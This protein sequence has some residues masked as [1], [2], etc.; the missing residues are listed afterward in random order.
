MTITNNPAFILIEPQMGENIGAVARAMLNF[1]LTDLR[2]VN[3]R[4]G[5][6]NERAIAMSSG[7]LDKMPPVRVFQNISDAIADLN[8]VYTT[9]AFDRFMVKPVMNPTDA[10]H[11]MVIR[12]RDGQNIGVVFGRERSGLTNDEIAAGQVLITIPV[13]DDFAS[14]NLAQASVVMAHEWSKHTINQFAPHVPTGKS[15]PATIGDFDEFYARL[16][17]ELDNGEFFR[18]P[19]MRDMM[20]RNIRNALLRAEFTDQELKTL[21]GVVTALTRKR[22]G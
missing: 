5:W 4:D 18:V 9:A 20:K 8:F 3:P 2:I 21:H 16:E 7:A 17:S 19:E 10:V 12:A 13:N 14:L 11:D 15:F 1:G 22:G 6:P